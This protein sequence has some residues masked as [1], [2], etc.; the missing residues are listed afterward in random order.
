MLNLQLPA[1]PKAKSSFGYGA[2]RKQ[3]P[4]RK[5]FRVALDRSQAR[6]IGRRTRHHC[7]E[8]FGWSVAVVLDEAKAA[9]ED[10]R[11]ETSPDLLFAPN[12]FDAHQ[13]HRGLAE[14]LPTAFRDH[15]VLGYEIVKW[16]G[17]LGR[18]NAYQRLNAALVE[19]KVDILQEHY[20]S[21]QHRPWYE[22]EAFVGLARIRGIECGPDT[23][24]SSTSARWLWIWG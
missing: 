14:L 3:H 10:L 24:R 22:R 20:P 5:V 1:P 7:A 16:D 19:A 9:V 17:D 12:R 8:D 11:A 13:D 6:S 2:S 18:S 23:P 21:Q 4:T 15:L